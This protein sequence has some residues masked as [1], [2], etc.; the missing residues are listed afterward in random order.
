MRNSSKEAIVK[1][2]LPDV[3]PIKQG[4]IREIFDLGDRLLIVATDKL[5]AFDVVLPDGIPGKG[6]VLT[7]LSAFWFQKLEKVVPNHLISTDLAALPDPL[8][9]VKHLQGRSMIVRKASPMAFECIVRGY[10]TG[11]GWKEYCESGQVSGIKLPEGISQG[12]ELHEPIF[13]PSTKAE[14]GEHDAPV[15]FEELVE[16]LGEDKAVW[17]RD[18][19][20]ELY[21]IAREYALERGIIIVD[22]KFEFG[23]AGET[24]IL[25]DECLTPDSSRFWPVDSYV[26]G[27][28][29][30]SLDKQ[31]VRDFLLRSGWD[32]TPPAPALPEDVITETSRRYRDILERLTGE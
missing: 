16:G 31:Y 1:I 21:K 28:P 8:R 26:P 13:T 23:E 32:K 9:V 6:T 7:R 2:E 22:T 30:L 17:I 15:T 18:H 12:E 4:K 27:K 10:L 20:L 24:L 29:G 19:S 11:S 25:I 5:S 3:L 14:L